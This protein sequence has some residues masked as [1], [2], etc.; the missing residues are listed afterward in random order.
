M[1]V[2]ARLLWIMDYSANRQRAMARILDKSGIQIPDALPVSECS[3]EGFTTSVRGSTR[4]LS[5]KNPETGMSFDQGLSFWDKEF[6]VVIQNSIE[7][8]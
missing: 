2:G 5:C 7:S 8:L 1:G 4:I 3:R 6:S